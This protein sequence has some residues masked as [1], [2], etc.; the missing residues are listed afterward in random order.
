MKRFR[1]SLQAVQTLRQRLE[2]VAF[3]AYSQTLVRRQQALDGLQAADRTLALTWV[4]L[5]EYQ[6]EGATAASLAAGNDYCQVLDARRQEAAVAVREAQKAVDVAWKKLVVARQRREA[7]EKYRQRRWGEYQRAV[8][9]E[10]QKILDE[11]AQRRVALTA[12]WSLHA[13]P[14]ET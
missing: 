9:R 4:A 14:T 8:L 11:I 3:E 5:R 13:L 7:V 2:R 6:L 10:D 12:E 1:F